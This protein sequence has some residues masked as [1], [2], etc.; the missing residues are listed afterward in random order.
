VKAAREGCF[1]ETSQQEITDMNIHRLTLLSLCA[2]ALFTAAAQQTMTT[3]EHDRPAAIGPAAGA[4]PFR[5]TVTGACTNKDDFSFTGIPAGLAP[6]QSLRIF[7]VVTG[8]GTHGQF[9]AHILAEEQVTPT[10]CMTPAGAPGLLAAVK[11]FVMVISFSAT[12]DQIYLSLSPTAAP[13]TECL[14][15]PGTTAPGRGTL[16]VVGGTGRYRGAT[17]SLSV[18]LDPTLLAV[19]ALGGDGFL[20]AFPASLDGQITLK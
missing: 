16:N 13:G 19:S 1:T 14:T 3:Q 17:G 12:D 2:G 9:L 10:G 18:F 20:S 15:G 8:R 5:A 7:C 11:G 4:Q 6:G